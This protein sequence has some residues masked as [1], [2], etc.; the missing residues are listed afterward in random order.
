MK[1]GF[2]IRVS[3]LVLLVATLAACNAPATPQNPTQALPT[4]VSP[5]II[6]V[7]PPPPTP[8]PIIPSL[9]PT[10]T[11]TPT[12]TRVRTPP[13]DEPTD[14]PLPTSTSTITPTPTPCT[15][16]TGWVV[17]RVMNYVGAPDISITIQNTQYIIAARRSDADFEPRC[18]QLKNP[19]G[20]AVWEW[21]ATFRSSN[22]AGI[23][24]VQPDTPFLDLVFC[25]PEG[26]LRHTGCSG[27]P[28]PTVPPIPSNTPEPG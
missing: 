5:R 3:P 13:T 27:A 4:I 10:I 15:L 24:N 20:A 14:T 28:G 22:D 1:Y 2:G 7:P 6:T 19:G 12:A 25:A 21:N 11:S 8:I 26:I 18:F 17:L 16:K 9:T 23:F